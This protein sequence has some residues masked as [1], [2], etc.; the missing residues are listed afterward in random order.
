MDKETREQTTIR[1][2]VELNEWLRQ[3]AERKGISFNSYVLM[4]LNEEKNRQK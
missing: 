2:P 4:I 1:L 3:A